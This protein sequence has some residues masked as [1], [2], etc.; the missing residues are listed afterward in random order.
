MFQRIR[1]RVQNWLQ[2]GIRQQVTASGVAFSAAIALVALAAFA[3]ANNLLFLILAA[4]MSTLLVSGFVSRL[5]IA[6]LELDL[7][8]PDHIS[9]QRKVPARFILKNE[10]GL[11][12]SFSIHLTG[13]EGSLL[14]AALY[15]PVI[16]G[17]QRAE[18]TVDVVFPRRGEHRENAFQFATRF[19]FGFTERRARVTLRGDV[20][21]YPCLDPQPGFHELL[22]SLTGDLEAAVRGHGHD[23]YRIRPYEMFESARHVDWKAT[24]HT[25]GLQVR[26]FARE[27]DQTLHIALDLEV[28][29]GCEEWFERAVDCCAFLI[30]NFAGKAARLHFRTQNFDRRLPENADVY[31]MLEYLARV[32]PSY[33]RVLAAPQE[34]D[35]IQIVFSSDPGRLQE[36]GWLFA[37][38]APVRIVGPDSLVLD[39]GGAK[40]AGDAKDRTRAREHHRHGADRG[41]GARIHHR[42]EPA[43]PHRDAG[44]QS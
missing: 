22:V 32:E 4:M 39:A 13:T 20:L 40:P 29:P 1:K 33:G 21:V 15:F 30:W 9:A 19:P 44:H 31:A 5:G 10:K 2:D 6:G 37:P 28:A 34:Q 18:E 17:G 38:G 26:E 23:F 25:G 16:P 14:S 43:S 8:L 36:Q 41:G 24:A 11:I 35:G 3:S 12:P 27:Q 7:Q 42:S